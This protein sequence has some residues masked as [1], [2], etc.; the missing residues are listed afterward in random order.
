MMEASRDSHRTRVEY[1]REHWEALIGTIIERVGLQQFLEI[2]D[3]V[4]ERYGH[5]T[6]LDDE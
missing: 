2:L 6:S 5:R 3:Y 1:D 4:L